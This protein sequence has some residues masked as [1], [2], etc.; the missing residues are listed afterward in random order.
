M[1]LWWEVGDGSSGI[2]IFDVSVICGD[3]EGGSCVIYDQLNTFRH[4]CLE[5]TNCIDSNHIK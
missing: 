1:Q 4:N 2:P 3:N 5:L